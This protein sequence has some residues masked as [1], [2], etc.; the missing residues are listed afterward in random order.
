MK[1]VKGDPA[2]EKSLRS[3]GAEKAELLMA[4]STY[5]D[6]N[7]EA[8]RIA[9]SVFGIPKL[10]AQ[11]S[12]PDMAEELGLMGVRVVQPQTATVLALEGALYF[13]AVFDILA[14]PA[15][16]ID[17]REV[18]LGNPQLYGELLRNVRLPGNALVMGL[19]RRGEVLVPRGD[20]RLR[21]DDL[22]M[23]VGPLESLRKAVVHLGQ[24]A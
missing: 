13:P 7:L 24:P 10:I 19:R 15:D 2:T 17:V 8:C 20:T 21:K 14:N 3:A 11:T 22:L 18:R 6:K 4:V 16:G 5:D 9:Q 12:D 23:L 1:V